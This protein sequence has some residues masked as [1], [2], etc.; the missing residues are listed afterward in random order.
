MIPI[1]VFGSG[2][3]AGVVQD[4]IEASAEQYLLGLVVEDD[5][6]IG[7]KDAA[8]FVESELP[9]TYKTFEF[10]CFLAV[11]EGRK[12]LQLAEK[13]GRILPKN[14][15]ATVTHPLSNR[16]SGSTLA[17]GSFVAA[18][19]TIGVGTT[20]GEHVLI[21]TN[22]SVDHD[23]TIEAFCSIAPNVAIGGNVVIERGA[24]IGIGATILP[25]IKIG[26]NAV[27]GAGAVVVKDV[28]ANKLVLGIPARVVQK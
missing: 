21:N 23:S 17:Q 1:L 15:F 25:G 10:M 11:G 19:A 22:S 16:L 4:A 12:R 20:V 5:L 14:C 3:H 7:A 24:F 28:P 8:V 2:G 18:G 13:I 27:V 26:K 9:S 6:N